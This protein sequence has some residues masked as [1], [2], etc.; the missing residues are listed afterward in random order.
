MSCCQGQ[1]KSRAPASDIESPSSLSASRRDDVVAI[2]ALT[3]EG[4]STLVEE[5]AAKLTVGHR[6]YVLA[7]D[8]SDGAGAAW[9]HAHGEVLGQVTEGLKTS[10]EVRLS[11]NDYERFVQRG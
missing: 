1:D 8:A 10:F 2:A 6:R 11:Q 9:L 3:G 7:L 4:V 5:V